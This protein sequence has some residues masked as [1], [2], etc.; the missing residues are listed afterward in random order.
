ME[1]KNGGKFLVVVIFIAL[2]LLGFGLNLIF[3]GGVMPHREIVNLIATPFRAAGNWIKNGVTGFFG[4]F[5]E[6]DALVREN[7]ELRKKISE[8]QAQLDETYALR[9]ENERLAALAGI[10]ARND[11]LEFIAADIVSL[12][13][14]GW[15]SS[16]TINKGT[17]DGIKKKDVVVCAEGLVGKISEVG[18]Y[19]ATVVTVIDP[20]IAV[21]AVVV[22]TGDA[23]MTEGSAALKAKGLCKLAYLPM[24]AVIVRGDT[25][26]TSGLGGLYPEGLLIG[27]VKD[28][29]VEGNG[30]TQYAIIEPA[31]DFGSLRRVYVISDFDAEG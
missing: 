8:L 29:V 25:V 13:T 7:E 23:A 4:A 17:A 24:D 26:R 14:S 28:I 9:I 21:G 5:S 15:R 31:A 12:N 19:S 20:Q 6:H 2:F 30:L 11:E 3:D 22:S 10:R 1:R 27:T 16:F 18:L